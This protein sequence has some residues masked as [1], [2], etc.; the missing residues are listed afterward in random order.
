MKNLYKNQSKFLF[1]A[2]EFEYPIQ[3]AF[4]LNENNQVYMFDENIIKVVHKI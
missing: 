3:R 2:T 4:Y 1:A